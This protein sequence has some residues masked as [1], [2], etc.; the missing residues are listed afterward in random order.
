MSGSEDII[1]RYYRPKT[2]KLKGVPE[3][4]FNPSFEQ[5]ESTHIFLLSQD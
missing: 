2:A 4:Q 5:G 3:L 1:C